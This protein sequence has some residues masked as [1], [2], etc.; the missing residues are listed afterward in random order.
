[1]STAVPSKRRVRPNTP[2]PGRGFVGWLVPMLDTSVGNKILVALTG[3]GLTLFVIVHMAGN[4]G[5]FR[6]REAY[7]DYAAFL[8]G[9]TGLLWTARVGLLLTFLL[10]IFLSLRLRWKSARARPI[11]Y[12][13][14]QIIQATFTSRTMVI[15]GAFIFLFTVFHIA[16][17]TLGLVEGTQV[18]TMKGVWNNVNYL[19]LRVDPKDPASHPDVY[20]MTYVGFHDAS[21]VG[22]YIVAMVILIV[23]LGHGVG[24]TLQSLGLNTPRTQPLVRALSWAV[25]LLVGLGNIIIVLAVWYDQVPPPPYN[26]K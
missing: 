6:G 24:S 25:A 8:K 10:H 12:S 20:A 2:P 18:E 16:H 13:Y 17:Y 19:D 9:H 14:R 21:I 3:L 23:H 7:N 11:P 5:V 15:S 4:L 22:I 1:M 26:V